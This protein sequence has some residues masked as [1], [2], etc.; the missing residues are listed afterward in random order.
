LI[1][2]IVD[3][4]IRF[5]DLFHG[6]QYLRAKLLSLLRERYTMLVHGIFSGNVDYYPEPCDNRTFRTIL[7]LGGNFFWESTGMTADQAWARYRHS[8][9]AFKAIAAIDR[10]THTE[11]IVGYYVLLP[12]TK[13]GTEQ[14]L[15]GFIEAG[16]HLRD[17]DIC[18]KFAGYSSLYISAVYARPGRA[19]VATTD[20][21]LFDVLD[22]KARNTRL[23]F[24]FVR[25]TS[26]E[27]RAI[28]KT[29]TGRQADLGKIQFLNLESNDLSS[30]FME[31]LRRIRKR[32]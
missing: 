27:G 31:R 7:T 9:D 10:K 25:P 29:L 26:P 23:H 4:L 1:V 3:W 19:Q 30:V 5:L 12:L 14:V 16:R 21:L 13:H 8:P 6:A 22:L 18:R 2:T 17:E 32:N 15:K 11:Q 20:W 24:V 28:F